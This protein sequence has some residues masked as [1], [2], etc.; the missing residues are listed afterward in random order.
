MFISSDV[1][2]QCDT[3][4][5]TIRLPRKKYSLEVM[6]RCIITEQ[7]PGKLYVTTTR[8]LNEYVPY[9][10]PSVEGVADWFQ[11]KVFYQFEQSIQS[12]SW[13]INHNLGVFPSVQ[14]YVYRTNE[15]GE[16]TL[17][18]ILPDQINVVDINTV[19]VKFLRN[20]SGTAHCIAFAS[21]NT[22]NPSV[23]D[24]EVT[25]DFLLTNN[26]EITIATASDAPLLDIKMSYTNA[27]STSIEYVG[28]DTTPSLRS[29]WVG[30]TEIFV[31]GKLYN[32][33]SYNIITTPLAPPYFSSGTILNGATINFTSLSSQPRQNLI[34][35]GRSPFGIVDRVY[36]RLIDIG[37]IN[38]IQSELYYENGNLYANP[39]IIRETF[40]PIHVVE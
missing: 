7:C 21:Q 19:E 36:D 10:P 33:R 30:V 12:S 32:V 3:C 22:I 24:A 38:A 13:L 29:P 4:N 6:Q 28:I 37:T 34:L 14:T 35:L 16:Q 31:G 26:G 9:I 11:R 27:T 8:T 15:N 25:T 17:V 2:Y 18:E 5:R 1:I 23:V 40:P 20:E 39:S